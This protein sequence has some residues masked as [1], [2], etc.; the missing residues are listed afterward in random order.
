MCAP[1]SKKQPTDQLTQTALFEKNQVLA[2]PAHT[3]DVF[4]LVHISATVVAIRD[5]TVNFLTDLY[6]HGKTILAWGVS[7]ARL[8]QAGLSNQ[9]SGD[10]ADLIFPRLRMWVWL[11]ASRRLSIRRSKNGI[12]NK[13]P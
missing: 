7:G 12:L 2:N 9:C 3:V 1:V 10:N 11:R 4:R 8:N 13:Q 5:H 6:G